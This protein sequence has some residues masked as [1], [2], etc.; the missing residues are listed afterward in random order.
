MPSPSLNY[1]HQGTRREVAPADTLERLKPL[2]AQVGITRVANIT[3]LDWIGVPV[4][5]AVRPASRSLVVSQGKGLSLVD[6]KVSAVMESIE[7]FHAER[8]DIPVRVASAGELAH[9]GRSVLDLARMPGRGEALDP[10]QVLLWT[11]GKDLGSGEEVFAPYG[12]MAIDDSLLGVPTPKGLASNSNGLASGNSR[13]EA[14]V[15]ALCEVIERDASTLWRA[16]PPARREG[17]A[18]DLA[19]VD[20][21]GCRALLDRFEACGIDVFAF[22]TTSDLGVPAYEVLIRE[23]G[24][25]P[26]RE[27]FAA[28]GSGCHLWRG[29]A[30]SRALTEAA[31]CRLT[32]I[33]GARE[34]LEGQDYADTAGRRAQTRQY[35]QAAAGPR[36]PFRPAGD[37]APDPSQSFSDSVEALLAALR[38]A[39]MDQVVAVDLTSVRFEIPVVKVLVPGLE[40]V[41]HEYGYV[42][43][44]RAVA[45]AAQGR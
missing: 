29:I 34:D 23:K 25:D 3:G 6:A 18:L 40:G 10:R 31:Q 2:L 43:K 32:H 8:P 44:A 12:C 22:E 9:E 30:L 14:I 27:P 39:G 36:R 11:R 28:V 35:L 33:A 13:A 15:H 1:H 16:A 19:S 4:A 26:E 45:A 37:P 7:M 38:R 20:D 41:D 24:C 5:T 42:P 21:P 17:T